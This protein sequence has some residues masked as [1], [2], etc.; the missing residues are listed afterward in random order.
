MKKLITKKRLQS[1]V[2][3]ILI[4]G[5]TVV[6]TLWVTNNKPDEKSV[7]SVKASISK[8]MILPEDE[9][10]TLAIVEDKHA[11]K[12]KF[13][14]DNAEKGD[15]IL[16]YANRGQAIIY[17]PGINKIVAVSQVTVD[18]AQAQAQGA[19]IEIRNGTSDAF[20][21][22]ELKD[23]L[24]QKY[25]TAKLSVTP[26][27]RKD[28]QK[29]IVIDNNDTKDN[30]FIQIMDELKAGRGVVPLGEP[31]ANTDIVIL[32]GKDYLERKRL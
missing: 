31:K 14:K 17:R 22:D 15:E 28:F 21:D 20:I 23:I 27:N 9:E 2:L 13:L 7:Q 12:D 32:I 30:L 25:P 16:I 18:A 1:L 24:A 29:T 11:L 26:A 19:T 3:L 6:I 8:L 5:L 10:P 4:V